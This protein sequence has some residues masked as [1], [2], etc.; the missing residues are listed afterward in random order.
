MYYK[1]QVGTKKSSRFDLHIQIQHVLLIAYCMH[2]WCTYYELLALN[3]HSIMKYSTGLV[4]HSVRRWGKKRNWTE[5]M[6]WTYNSKGNSLRTINE[7]VEWKLLRWSIVATWLNC[8]CWCRCFFSS[9]FSFALYAHHV[10]CLWCF[11]LFLCSWFAV[12]F[13]L[14]SSPSSSHA[15]KPFQ[16]I[17]HRMPFIA[18]SNWNVH[19]ALYATLSA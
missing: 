14:S 9:E 16:P 8:C 4:P 3:L 2:T 13:P 18:Y 12:L 1:M 10:C 15:C 11:N 7:W 17:P 19:T 6:Q 5:K